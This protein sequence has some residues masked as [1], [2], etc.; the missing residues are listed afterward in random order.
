[1]QT[2]RGIAGQSRSDLFLFQHLSRRPDG[3]LIADRPVHSPASGHVL[4]PIG[5]ALTG[6]DGRFAGV[7]MAALEPEQLREFYRPVD[8]G[9]HGRTSVLP[10]EGIVVLREPSTSE[11]MGEPAQNNPIFAAQRQN[12]TVGHLRGPLTEGGRS[13]L[14]AYRLSSFPP[15]VVAVSLAE[16]DVLAGWWPVSLLAVRLA[17]ALR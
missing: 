6:P 14:T 10:P 1:A 8:A 11:P 12:P 9:P 5:R 17:A 15:L 2:M 3:G 7:I 13:Y 4:L 16:K